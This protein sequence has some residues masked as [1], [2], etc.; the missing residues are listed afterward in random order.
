M[1]Y[2]K[3]YISELFIY[4]TLRIDKLITTWHVNDRYILYDRIL[5][6]RLSLLSSFYRFQGFASEKFATNLCDR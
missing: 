3:R 2:K 1:L 4:I 6:D 5:N